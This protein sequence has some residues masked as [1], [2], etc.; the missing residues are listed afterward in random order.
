MCSDKNPPPCIDKPPVIVHQSDPGYPKN[1]RKVKG[2]GAVVLELIVGTDG[3]AH[4]VHVTGSLGPGF[5]EEAIKAVKRWTFKP[6]TSE[7]KPVP[8]PISVHVVFRVV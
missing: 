1:T 6:A 4:D 3:L 7:G 5:D 8:A 2:Q